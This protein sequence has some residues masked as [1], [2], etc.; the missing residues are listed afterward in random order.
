MTSLL[1]SLRMMRK[2]PYPSLFHAHS[3]RIGG[4]RKGREP[5]ALFVAE[6]WTLVSS[7]SSLSTYP[8]RTR[9]GFFSSVIPRRTVKG[10]Y[11]PIDARLVVV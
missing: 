6:S 3:F 8:R 9:E 4:R 7:F 5:H 10:D 1:S 2:G 11:F